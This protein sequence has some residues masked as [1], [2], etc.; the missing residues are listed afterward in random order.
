MLLFGVEKVI[1]KLDLE[2]GQFF[3]ISKDTCKEELGRLTNEQF[4]DFGLLLGSRYLRTFPLFENATY[5]GKTWNIRDALNIFNGA[6]RHV[7]T[8][9]SQYEEDRRVQDLQYLDRYKRAYMSI[10]HHV[11]TD[12][13]GK[14]GPLEP[15]SAPS[16]VHELIGQRLPEELY[17]Y[18]SRG[19]LGPNIPNH[20]TTGQLTVPLPFGV[21]D[22][23]VYRH[24]AGESLMPIR[25]QAVGLL[26]NCLHRFYHTKVINVRLWHEDNSAR[27]INLKTLPSVRESIRSWRINH[28]QLPTEL[29]DKKVCSLRVLNSNDFNFQTDICR[30]LVEHFDLPLR[31]CRIP[32]SF[33]KHFPLKNLL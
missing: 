7:P 6:N 9:C 14:V 24:L 32:S 25:E 16:D 33:Q 13:E 27:T 28:K 10:K 19:V 17:Y 5:P 4:L 29:A 3:W 26:S 30:C 23:E 11:I 1:L 12:N 22:S 2:A 18:I 21:E 15:E 8:L 20:L 31:V